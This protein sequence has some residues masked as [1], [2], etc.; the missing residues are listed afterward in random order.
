MQPRSLERGVVTSEL[1]AEWFRLGEKVP[2]EEVLAR[3]WEAGVRASVGH[4]GVHAPVVYDPRTDLHRLAG[5]GEKP[6]TWFLVAKV[7]REEQKL[8]RVVLAPDRTTLKVGEV[9]PVEEVV[10]RITSFP[11]GK[12]EVR[13][14]HSGQGPQRG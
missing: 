14:V 2:L 4:W 10:R 3:L 9:L 12:A 7:P 11:G 8:F 6:G 5:P 1:L 13:P